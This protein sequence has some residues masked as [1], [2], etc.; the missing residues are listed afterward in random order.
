MLNSAPEHAKLDIR[1]VWWSVLMQVWWYLMI[2]VIPTCVQYLNDFAMG[3]LLVSVSGQPNL[4]CTCCWQLLDQHTISVVFSIACD[5]EYPEHCKRLMRMP[6][7]CMG[8]YARKICCW[9]CRND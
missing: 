1:C 4:F 2:N 5:D 9:S 7:G 3:T 6:M 8:D